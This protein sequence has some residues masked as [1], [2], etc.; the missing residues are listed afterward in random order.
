VFT[1]TFSL[2]LLGSDFQ[3]QKFPSSG[4]PNCPCGHCPA[5]SLHAT[6]YT[7]TDIYKANEKIF[8]A[9]GKVE[10]LAVMSG[11][12]GFLFRLHNKK[13]LSSDLS[14]NRMQTPKIKT[15]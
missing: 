4:V 11:D 8:W 9:P 2:L 6:I 3:Q 12:G 15:V 7:I 10:Q 1:V 5:A 13:H 14:H